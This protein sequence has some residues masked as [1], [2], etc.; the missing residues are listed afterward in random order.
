[1]YSKEDYREILVDRLFD[2][3]DFSPEVFEQ[4]KGLITSTYEDIIDFE[5]ENRRVARVEGNIM[6]QVYKYMYNQLSDDN[7][8]YWVDVVQGAMPIN[9]FESNLTLDKMREFIDFSKGRR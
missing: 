3:Y 7:K 2:R 6:R 9:D 5:Q 4:V 1:M 8:D